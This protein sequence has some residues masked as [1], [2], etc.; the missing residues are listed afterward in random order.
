M[1]RRCSICDHPEYHAINVALVQREPWRH[2]A[3]QWDVS[4]GALQ[5][6]AQ[7]HLPALLAKAKEGV[8][9]SDAEILASELE[10]VKGDVRRLK[11]KAEDEGDLRT[12][13]LGCDKAL[14][15][16]ELQAKVEQIIKTAPQVNLTLT[17]EYL[18]IRAAI[19]EA[20]DGYP[21][22][23]DA[24]VAKMLEIEGGDGLN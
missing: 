8:E 15:A 9:R 16:L 21:E 24:I 19:V 3:A 1:P 5:R 12:A 17:P 7:D 2:I 6:H 10:E 20:V 22:V 11:S 14:K 4:T 23:R 18:Y 13:L